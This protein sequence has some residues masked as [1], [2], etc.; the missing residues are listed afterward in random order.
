MLTSRLERLMTL[1]RVY[2]RLVATDSRRPKLG[3]TVSSFQTTHRILCQG[4]Q[5]TTQ[6]QKLEGEIPKVDHCPN[7]ALYRP[8]I[9]YFA[10]SAG[11]ERERKSQICRSLRQKRL[12]YYSLIA[13]I[14][15]NSVRRPS[16]SI[17]TS[18]SA[19]LPIAQ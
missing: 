8:D 4:I 15:P 9:R 11:L 7:A 3:R 19:F 5:N 18:R 16:T 6:G 13:H 2:H 14:S 1:P 12:M 10:T 17:S